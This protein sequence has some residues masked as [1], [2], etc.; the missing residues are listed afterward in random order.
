[1]KDEH[2]LYPDRL[3]PNREKHPNRLCSDILFQTNY[4]WVDYPNTYLLTNYVQTSRKTI[5]RQIMSG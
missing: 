1:M 3:H 4:I 5:F 2:I